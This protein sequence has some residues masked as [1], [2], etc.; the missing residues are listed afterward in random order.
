MTTRY[1]RKSL[2]ALVNHANEVVPP[3]DGCRFKMYAD[4]VGCAV[5]F[6]PISGESWQREI[7]DGRFTPREAAERFVSW[8]ILSSCPREA[9]FSVWD[10][11]YE[12][13]IRL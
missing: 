9:A 4:G 10:Y 2:A 6:T 13:G 8:L 12:Q 5:R 7:Y 1:T 3:C 11:A